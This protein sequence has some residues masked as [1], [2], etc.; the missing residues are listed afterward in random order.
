MRMIIGATCFGKV[1]GVIK[2]K[3]G[4]KTNGMILGMAFQ[5]EILVFL[6]SR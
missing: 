4:T 2:H 1:K 3:E 6:G 5:D